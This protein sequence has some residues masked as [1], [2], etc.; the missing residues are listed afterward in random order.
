MNLGGV[1]LNPQ[2][3]QLLSEV[4]TL[5][6]NQVR[7]RA[8]TGNDK[9][10]EITLLAAADVADDGIPEI[11]YFPGRPLVEEILV[12][13]LFHLK[14][15]AIRIDFRFLDVEPDFE[16][17]GKLNTY[18]LDPIVHQNFF[19][20]MRRMGFKPDRSLREHLIHTL[21]GASLDEVPQLKQEWYRPLYYF[22][23]GLETADTTLVNQLQDYYWNLGWR[24][25]L[26]MGK[27]L[28]EAAFGTKSTWREITDAVVNC[29]NVYHKCKI[30]FQLYQ[31]SAAK[32]GDADVVKVTLVGQ[33]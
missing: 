15:P 20:A 17:F 21:S 10:A 33:P 18:L 6:R 25:E 23:V 29:L 24:E 14:Y 28:V 19:P 27:S 8:A 1:E 30:R 22:A 5:Y 12:H 3:A 9:D 7:V 13:E 11:I 32:A 2:S 31:A 26:Q 16:I 4:E